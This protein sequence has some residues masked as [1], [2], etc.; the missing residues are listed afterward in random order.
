MEEKQAANR[1]AADKRIT[2]RQQTSRKHGRFHPLIWDAAM[3][4]AYIFI[5]GNY[6]I[7]N[8]FPSD[9]HQMIPYLIGCQ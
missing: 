8:P 7:Q 6:E 5:D 3:L 2:N 9:T 4:P 1:Q